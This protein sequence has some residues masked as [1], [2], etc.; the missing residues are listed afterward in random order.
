MAVRSWDECV[1][2]GHGRGRAERSTAEA[3]WRIDSDLGRP[4]DVNEAWRSP[5]QANANRARWLAYERYLK[6]GP[7]APKAPYALGADESVHCG[8]TAVDSDDWYIPAAAAVWRRH[9]FRQTARY[10]GTARD[11]PWHG[12]RRDEWEE[13]GARTA[14]TEATLIIPKEWDEMAT[15]EEVRAEAK[16]GFIEALSDVAVTNKLAEVVQ[17]EL[18][19][20][21][22]GDLSLIPIAELGNAMF[23]RSASTRRR[24]QVQST[25]HAGFIRR[26]LE[27]RGMRGQQMSSA[28]VDIVDAYCL[29]VYPPDTLDVDV[30]ALSAALNAISKD[31]S[32][33]TIR[34]AVTDAINAHTSTI[35]FVQKT[36]P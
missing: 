15:R 26:A 2:L 1:D 23:L 31:Q 4:A 7:W 22:Y 36:T 16:A 5:E 32:T 29:A 20:R 13:P 28:E 12:E 19:E 25:D 3:I 11:E 17:N 9:G 33:E 14:G 18:N 35:A 10:P 34:A 21:M 6:G 27:N 24:I 30:A 8:G